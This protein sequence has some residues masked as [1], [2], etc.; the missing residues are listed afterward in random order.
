MKVNYFEDSQSTYINAGFD[1]H[2]LGHVSVHQ[3]AVLPG[4]LATVLVPRPHLLHLPGLLVDPGLPL[5]VALLLGHG[6][7]HRHLLGLGEQLNPILIAPLPLE[8]LLHGLVHPHGLHILLS[9]TRGARLKVALG[10]GNLSAN[11]QGKNI[12]RENKRKVKKIF[13]DRKIFY[14]F[15]RNISIYFRKN[16]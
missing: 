1:G 8:H 13:M 3:L 7:T 12:L 10:G 6:H 5:G 14:Y 4:D 9:L 2:L 16:I 15:L 11:L